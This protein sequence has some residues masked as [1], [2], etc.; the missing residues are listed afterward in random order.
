MVAG[1]RHLICRT[2]RTPSPDAHAEGG[3]T[4]RAVLALPVSYKPDKA[5]L[6]QICV[7]VG[8]LRAKTLW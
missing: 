6:I 1:G 2:C 5:S 4:Q 8:R 3:E 7:G